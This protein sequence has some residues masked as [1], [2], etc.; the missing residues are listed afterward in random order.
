MS[1]SWHPITRLLASFY[2]RCRWSKEEWSVADERIKKLQ[3]LTL[4]QATAVIREHRSSHEFLK[5][6]EILGALRLA[7]YGPKERH[8]VS[9]TPEQW[10][11]GKDGDKAQNIREMA[12]RVR[13]STRAA[14]A[15][16]WKWAH[17][18]MMRRKWVP[19]ERGITKAKL[20]SITEAELQPST[21][22]MYTLLY[23]GSMM[24]AL[25]G[26]N[27]TMAVWFQQEAAA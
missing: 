14:S 27:W 15:K 3:G 21:Q 22:S 19:F 7:A 25:H 18:E 24:R 16:E 2:P 23:W 8:A 5:T 26:E 9:K 10:E 13:R 4:E 12:E 1:E 17:E 11:C 20:E 6:S